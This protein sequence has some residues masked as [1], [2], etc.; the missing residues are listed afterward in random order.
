MGAAALEQWFS[1]SLSSFSISL[2]LLLFS[3]LLQVALCFLLYISAFLLSRSVYLTL[4]GACNHGLSDGR[5]KHNWIFFHIFF[6]RR[7]PQW[8]LNIWK[9]H[10]WVA[11][12]WGLPRGGGR[13][14]GCSLAHLWSVWLAKWKQASHLTVNCDYFFSFLSKL[15][16]PTNQRA[17]GWWIYDDPLFG[18]RDRPILSLS[19]F[20]LPPLSAILFYSSFCTHPTHAEVIEKHKLH[21][22]QFAYLLRVQ[23]QSP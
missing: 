8:H 7:K 17:N 5:W 4:W 19:V 23:S 2:S 20:W 3:F 14:P 1:F 18:S 22:I 9:S 6:L 11:N 15:F 13:C 16:V 21:R 12:Q 10:V